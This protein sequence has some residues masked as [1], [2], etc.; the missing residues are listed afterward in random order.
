MRVAIALLGL[1]CG[2]AHAEGVFR[3]WSPGDAATLLRDAASLAGT[4]PGVE[5]KEGAQADLEGPSLRRLDAASRGAGRSSAGLAASPAS[6]YAP[7]ALRDALAA[8]DAA[9]AQGR[10][11]I[12]LFDIDDTLVRASGRT[13]RILSEFAAEPEMRRKYGA[14]LDK[15]ASPDLAKLAYYVSDSLVNHGVTD[16]ALI[17]EAGRYWE[18]RFFSNSYLPEDPAIR[19][20]VAYVKAALVKG[21]IVV[22]LTGRWEEM[23]PGTE[24]GLAKNGFPAPNGRDVLLFM[25]PTKAMKDSDY[26][27][28][29][30]P[31]IGRLGVVV[32][33]FENEPK[34]VNLFK[35][36]FPSGLMIF[37][38]TAHSGSKD[39]E[40][41]VIAPQAS[42]PWVPDFTLP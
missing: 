35:R 16:A 40:G 9:I 17:E 3:D 18:E 8:V 11:P 20:A 19:G 31:E 22:Y 12:V 39:S 36:H 38:D 2:A 27:D 4:L 32:A 41:R 6:R 24:A 30:L 28:A 29:K 10:K 1:A 34:N 21:T 42:I 23:R 26:K 14:E 13:R 15:I 33:G 7:Q 25:K 37:L 5:A